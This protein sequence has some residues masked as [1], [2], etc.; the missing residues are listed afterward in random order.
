MGFPLAVIPLISSSH[1]HKAK[2]AFLYASSI[3]SY[4]IDKQLATYKTYQAIEYL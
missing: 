3:Y 1:V 4:F 2:E